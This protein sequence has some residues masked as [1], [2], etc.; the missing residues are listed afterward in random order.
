[1]P[2]IQGTGN[3]LLTDDVIA[4]EAL[5][6]L[7]NNLIGARFVNRNHEAKFGAG[8]K[9]GDQITI[10][11]PFRVKSASGRTLVVQ[12]MVDQSVTM[13]IDRQEHVGLR[14]TVNDRTLNINDFS[15]RYLR[16]AVVQLA[17]KVD[18]SIYETAIQSAFNTT[19]VP[20][21][22]TT[23]NSMIDAVASNALLGWPVDGMTKL[24][25]NPL[26]AAAHAKAIILAGNDSMTKSAIERSYL[27]S[28]AGVDL[29]ST[30]QL[31]VHT[32]GP[33]GGT[34]LVN[35]A[36]QTGA[37]LVTDGWTAAAALRL[38]KGDVFT[39]AGVFSINPQTYQSTGQLQS[40]VVT[41]AVSS[42][43][44]GAATIPISPAINPGTLTGLDGD[45]NSISLA[46]YQNVTASPAD[47]A[48]IT[49][50]GAAGTAY[51]QNLMMH[52]DA[53]SLAV[54]ELALPQTAVVAKRQSDADSGLSITMTGAFN[55]SDYEETY[56]LDVL[57]GVKNIYPEL[58]RRVFGPA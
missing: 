35:G 46:A 37:S 1:M 34:P 40:F 2:T 3:A 32:V 49:V 23:Y 9:I 13:E 30:A 20:G 25:L 31:P 17:H 28:V 14:F 19:G 36:A 56:R 41:A 45:G 52:H 29:F 26:D 4:K 47:N 48:A 7:K 10:K 15:D 53:I 39:I 22:G 27:G 33:L 18:Y 6:L 44:A 5:R 43:G 11:K 16:P 57:W 42:S 38:N 24:V 50:L 54:V 8:H 58:T 12:P 55:V 51:L 21:N